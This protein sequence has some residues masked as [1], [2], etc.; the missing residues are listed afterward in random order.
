MAMSK[1][2]SLPSLRRQNLLA[3]LYVATPFCLALGN[4]SS[5]PLTVKLWLLLLTPR[6]SSGLKQACPDGVFVTLTPGDPSL[7]S[8]VIFVRDGTVFE[9]FPP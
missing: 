4:N 3:E 9:P 1:F 2:T 8:G 6:H 5:R 7:W